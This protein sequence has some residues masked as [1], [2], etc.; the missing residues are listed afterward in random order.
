MKIYGFERGEKIATD[1][2]TCD[3]AILKNGNTVDLDW[4]R[5]GI[6]FQLGKYP[7]ELSQSQEQ[8]L[9]KFLASGKDWISFPEGIE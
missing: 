5:F 7:T 6:G 9:E 3:R 8:A 2:A 4:Q 1:C